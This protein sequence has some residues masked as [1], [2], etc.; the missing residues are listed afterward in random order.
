MFVQKASLHHT[1]FKYGHS[2]SKATKQHVHTLQ[3][4][5][6]LLWAFRYMNFI[7]TPFLINGY[8]YK[9]LL[10]LKSKSPEEICSLEDLHDVTI[11]DCF[12]VGTSLDLSTIELIHLTTRWMATTVTWGLLHHIWLAIYIWALPTPH[13]HL[14]TN[15]P[16]NHVV[17][18]WTIAKPQTLS[19]QVLW[20]KPLKLRCKHHNEVRMKTLLLFQRPHEFF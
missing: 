16:K 19:S 5:V 7:Q 14:A 12:R 2:I 4:Y 3:Q 9:A 11:G 20:T 8:Q 18:Y 13:K 15:W 6:A 17:Q 1:P 10:D